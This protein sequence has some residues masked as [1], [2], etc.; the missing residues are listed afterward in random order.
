MPR[1]LRRGTGR[2]RTRRFLVSIMGFALVA[3]AAG[4]F[5]FSG[6]AAELL[7]LLRGPAGDF[8]SALAELDRAV[9]QAEPSA[10]AAERLTGLLDA[11]ER[12]ALSVGEGLSVLKRR[13][14]LAGRFSGFRSSYAEAAVSLAARFPHAESAAAVAAEALLAAGEASRAA[15]YALRLTDPRFGAIAAAVLIE[16]RR[17]SNPEGLGADADA[18]FLSAAS[19][20]APGGEAADAL[21]ADAAIAR[22]LRGDGAAA[23]ALVRGRSGSGTS[24]PTG[25]TAARLRAELE[26]DFG[27]ARAAA[28]FFSLDGGAVASLRRADAATLAGDLEEAREAWKAVVAATADPELASIALYDLASVGA[29]GIA[30]TA[31]AQAEERAYLGRLL[32]LDPGHVAGAIRLSR[33]LGAEGGAVLAAA[34][35]RKGDGLLELE[36]VRRAAGDAGSARTVGS[37]WM[38]MNARPDD[39]RIARWSAWYM[40]TYGATEDVALVLRAAERAAFRAP[41]VDFHAALRAA[42]EG[43]LEEAEAGFL[44]AGAVDGDWRLAADLAVLAEARGSARIALEQY[45]IAASLAK[46]GRDRSALQVRVARCM[47]ALGKEREARRVLAYALELDPQ[48]RTA[49]VELKR[50]GGY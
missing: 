46:A 8:R 1:T 28:A 21:L 25:G 14:A 26:Y 41:W 15:D 38:L 43:R 10:E 36:A 9:P 50:L 23:L 20:Y 3:S 27:D 11:A 13:R 48:N 4:V 17:L 33:L 42:R 32:A 45:E 18:A 39:W 6:R 49:R 37:L 7:A 22:L 12:R 29:P 16:S 35:R 44:R 24:T 34:I 30:G 19:V 47:E 5:I 2:P 31:E 40:E